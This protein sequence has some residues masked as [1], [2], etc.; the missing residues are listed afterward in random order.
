MIHSLKRSCYLLTIFLFCFCIMCLT[1]LASVQ[2][3]AALSSTQPSSQEKFIVVTDIHFSPFASCQS[4]PCSLIKNLTDANIQQWDSYLD[5]ASEKNAISTY[6]Q[7]TN[8]PLF[9]L[10]LKGIHQAYQDEKPRFALELG[11]FLGH[12]YLENYQ[13]YTGSNTNYN[14][15]VKKT[16]A[17]IA[18]KLHQAM[19]TIAMYPVV[20]N[21]D[22]YHGDYNVTPDGA[23][24][25]DTASSWKHYF[26]LTASQKS[27]FADEFPTAGYY[28]E[29]LAHHIRLI[30]LNSVLFSTKCKGTNLQG[31]ATQELK[32]LKSQ[33]AEAA[34]LKQHVILMMHIPFGINAYLTLKSKTLTPTPFW[35]STTQ[36]TFEHLLKTYHQNIIAILTGHLHIDGYM[37][38][39]NGS[40]SKQSLLPETITPA[41]S[42]LF[43]NNPGFKV[44]TYNLQRH[45]LSNFKT[46]YLNLNNKTPNWALE[47]DFGNQYARDCPRC[48]LSQ[49]MQKLTR[50][51][52]KLVALYRKYYGVGHKGAQP[53][54][55]TVNWPFYWCSITSFDT[56]SYLTCLGE[57]KPA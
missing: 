35:N 27:A 28:T 47:Y 4:T 12:D 42:P 15:F 57:N 25:M 31:A 32:W 33:L 34:T 16:L 40:T 23:F 53:I 56:K 1:A 43:G 20:G 36:A 45:I 6:H 30:G 48:S 50:Y 9:L 19:P 2:T 10:A 39:N 26:L 13:K 14:V 22:S 55:D 5:K 52:T 46:Y 44:Y 49:K 41:I 3:P 8:Y 11:D 18:Y 24:F 38:Y 51:N 54:S 21:N 7:D 17:Y 37:L 29:E